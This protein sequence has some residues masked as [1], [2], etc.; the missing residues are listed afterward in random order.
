MILAQSHQ[1]PLNGNKLMIFSILIFVLAACNPYRNIQEVN[2]ENAKQA[3]L[4]SVKYVRQ[5]D[6]LHTIAT[7]K[8]IEEQRIQDALPKIPEVIKISILLPFNASTISYDTL[9]NIIGKVPDK[10]SMVMDYYRGMMMALDTLSKQG[11]KIQLHIYDTQGDTNKLKEILNKTEIQYSNLIIGPVFNNELPIAARFAARFKIPLVSPFSSSTSFLDKNSYYI[12]ANATIKTHCEKV[13]EYLSEKY[14]PKKV[15]LLYNETEIE[16]NYVSYFKNKELQLANDVSFIIMTDSSKVT[17]NQIMDTLSTIDTNYIII[18]SFNETF[19]SNVTRKLNELPSY[20]KLVVIGMPQWKE[21]QTL[22]LDYLDKINCII[23]STLWNDK[24]DSSII[25]FSDRY[26]LKYNSALSEI[27]IEGYDQANYFV[28]QIHTRGT[29]I[30]M[31]MQEA[32]IKALG[33]SFSFVGVSKQRIYHSENPASPIDY[34]ENKS[35]NVLEFKG[36]KLIRIKS[37]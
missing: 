36:G 37:L 5:S 29:D 24:N 3:Y 18:P 4:D 10:T 9:G 25:K 28:N 12:I 27:A 8:K 20:Y 33:E 7:L 15:I 26:S 6:S 14:Q 34:F 17:Y 16:R 32:S 30:F 22:R 21:S 2:S 13:Y 1:Q 11:I 19:I 23:S 31:I 35:I